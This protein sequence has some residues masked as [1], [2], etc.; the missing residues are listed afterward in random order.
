MKWNSAIKLFN[1]YL[2]LEKGLS[3]N[4]I[5]A[6]I[7]DIEM[8][9]DFINDSELN[10]KPEKIELKNLKD[11]I[12]KINEFGLSA[13]SQARIIS[14]IRAFYK[15]LL[16]DDII[17]TNP[18]LLLELPRLGT[19][20]PVILSIEEIDQMI[21]VIDLSSPLG[22]RNKTIIEVLY[23]CGLR[24]SELINLKIS[25]LHLDESYI[26]IIGKGNKER[27]VPIGQVAINE[28]VIYL[29]NIRNKQ[30]TSKGHE[31]FVFLNRNGRQLTR[32]MIFTIIKRLAEK[33]RIEKNI[34]PHTFRH[35]FAT[36][37]VE[38]GANLRAVQDMLGHESIITTEIYTHLDTQ[39][40]RQAITEYH[41]RSA[42]NRNKNK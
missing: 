40:L 21:N 5:E 41:P 36:H 10:I 20:L 34:S 42:K 13:R 8:L 3:V 37:L 27:L 25:S 31:D 11:F 22:H 39:Y 38:G 32:V 7:H 18:S 14:G 17:D 24:V 12:R 16:L 35:S 1:D 4:S 9:H 15:F 26:Q 29:T 19:K 6:Y 33:A 30:K 2:M 23:G 28:L